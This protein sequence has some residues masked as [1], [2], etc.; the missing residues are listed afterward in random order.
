MQQSGVASRDVSAG[1]WPAKERTKYLF[2]THL[3]PAARPGPARLPLMTTASEAWA[4]CSTVGWGLRS[5]HLNTDTVMDIDS[6]TGT[7]TDTGR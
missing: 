2:H 7:N 4:G 3:P 5:S 6:N 1:G